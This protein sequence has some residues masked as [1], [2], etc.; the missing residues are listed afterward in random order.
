MASITKRGK[1]WV[2]KIRRQGHPV[3]QQTFQEKWDAEAWARKTES[4]LERGLY[5]AD[6]AEAR[7][8][9]FDVAMERYLSEFVDG[10]KHERNQK[11]RAAA[12]L[13]RSGWGSIALANLRGAQLAKYIKQRQKDGVAG[14]TIRLDLALISCVYRVACT[15]WGMEGLPNPAKSVSKPKLAGGRT[16]RLELGELE[17]LL[18]HCAPK[19]KPVILFALETAMRREEIATLTRP[20]INYKK[21]TAF[22]PQTKN[23]EARIVPL[24][25]Q[26]IE[27]LLGLPARI[28]NGPM[29]GLH[30]DRITNY[31]ALARA[32]ACI[33]DLKFH[34]LR[35][36]A[37]TRLF[38]RRD[39]DMMEIASITGHKTL[40]MLKRYTHL[41]AED[42]ARRLG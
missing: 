30:K 3:I 36:E 23:G 4:E 28:D 5:I 2:A 34:D 32:K 19:L 15:D 9:T 29:F 42:L 1:R 16:R 21:R 14:N 27:I 33:K 24:S 17:N 18:K 11:N 35:H 22:L 8:I 41:R 20:Q 40:S 6:L 31:F 13:E 37:T 10:T 12:L 7:R 26:A 25:S 38:E 39:F